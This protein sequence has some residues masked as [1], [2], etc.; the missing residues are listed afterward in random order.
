LA[1]PKTD[2]AHLLR[3]AGFGGTAASVNRLA[4][5]AWADVV[6]SVLDTSVNPAVVAPPQ[7]SDAHASEYDRWV[8][9]VQWWFERIRKSPAPI[10][11]KMT[12]FWHGHFC[13]SQDK[14]FRMSHLW[15]Q[16]NLF[17]NQGMGKFELLTQRVAVQPAML[18]Y[19]DNWLNMVGV[20]QENFARELMEL[21][22]LDVGN[23]TQDDV[24]ASA[25]AWT[26]HGLTAD[27]GQYRFRKALHDND[28][29][30][31]MGIT[32]NWD[33]P[34]IVHQILNGATTRPLAAKFIARKLW[35]FF[36]YPNPDGALVDTLATSFMAT[37]LDVGKLLRTIFL[38]PE[39]LSSTARGALVRSPIEFVAATMIYTGLQAKAVHP[40]WWLDGMG[41]E[42]F[43]PPNVSGWKQNAYWIS[44]SAFWARAAFVRNIVWQAVDS[45]AFLAGTA[46]HTP[47]EAA[48]MAFNAVNIDVPS[49][50]TRAALEAFVTAERAAS[51]W[52]ERPN[53]AT[54]ILLSPEFQLA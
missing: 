2:V 19:L 27:Q 31:F 51:G 9:V 4:K 18:L 12:L 41:Q 42:P 28:P 35:S 49:T 24:V 6:D 20:P 14:I 21:F 5:L 47:A 23:Y 44:S 37:D 38:R 36:A 53:L 13:S 34:G 25:R 33:G 48:Q 11:E 30:T 39:F 17:R 46:Q 32:R 22:T 29:K 43:Y 10:Q 16:N 7:L 50:T 15:D 54:L 8:A 1:T 52:A 40:E 3:R 26:G 45:T